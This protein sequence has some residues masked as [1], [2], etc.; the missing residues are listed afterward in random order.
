[1]SGILLVVLEAL[2]LVAEQCCRSLCRS[3]P[4]GLFLEFQNFRQFVQPLE[5][6]SSGF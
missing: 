6:F 1:M 4:Q 5:F 2:Y 3:D